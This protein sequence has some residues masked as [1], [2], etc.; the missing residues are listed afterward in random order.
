MNIFIAGSIGFVVGIA[1]SAVVRS[2]WA[3]N[4]AD[5]PAGAGGV[6]NPDFPGAPHGDGR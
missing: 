1:T 3:S 5:D 4:K 2:F 6:I